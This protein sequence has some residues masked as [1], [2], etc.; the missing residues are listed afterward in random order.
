MI[1]IELIFILINII[2]TTLITIILGLSGICV[3]LIIT[4]ILINMAIVGD[5]ISIKLLN[6]VI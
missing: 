1:I 4:N 2:I 3:K 5:T 6:P